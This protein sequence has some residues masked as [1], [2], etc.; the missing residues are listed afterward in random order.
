MCDGELA[1]E[2][3]LINGG[4]TMLFLGII[5]G[6]NTTLPL[7]VAGGLI[8]GRDMAFLFLAGQQ[9]GCLCAMVNQCAWAD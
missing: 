7:L 2:G 4:E 5:N 8:D 3:G 1:C 9:F 6:G